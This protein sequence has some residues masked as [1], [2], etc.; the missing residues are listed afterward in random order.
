MGT[1]I[2]NGTVVNANATTRADV[3]IEQESISLVG[4]SVDPANHTVRVDGGCV[5]A[6]VDHATV[7]FG[8]ATPSGFALA[9]AAW[10]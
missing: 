7:A 4:G 8:M 5:W 2:K 9:I 1:L 10:S 6:D 3:L